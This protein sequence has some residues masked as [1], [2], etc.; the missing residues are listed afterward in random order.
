MSP[1]SV[2]IGPVRFVPALW[3]GHRKDEGKHDVE[4]TRSTVSRRLCKT[5]WSKK[6]VHATPQ[7]TTYQS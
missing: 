7:R 6:K 4:D 5:G 3:K 1:I 2:G